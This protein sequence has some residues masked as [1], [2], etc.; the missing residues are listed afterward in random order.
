MPKKIKYQSFVYRFLAEAQL[1]QRSMGEAQRSGWQQFVDR[2]RF[3]Y[4]RGNA[5]VSW[6]DN[7]ADRLSF[8]LRAADFYARGD[9]R[10]HVARQREANLL[11]GKDAIQ[12]KNAA[13][14]R[15][16]LLAVAR[17]AGVNPVPETGAVPVRDRARLDAEEAFHDQWAE[18]VDPTPFDVRKANE[19]CTSP[20]MRYIRAQLGSL[21]GKKLLDV[22][23]GLGE[24]SVYF[25]LEGARVTA[26]DISQGMLEAT[27]RLARLNGVMV[28][29]HKSA[30]EQTNLPEREAFDIIYA[31][32]LLHHVDIEATL[33]LLKPHLAADGV[34]VSWDPVAYN[35]VIK[36]YRAIATRVRTPDE[37]PLRRADLR[38]IKREF[39]Q[40]E[41][42]FF[43]LTSLLIFICMAVLQRRS[44]NRERFWK[45]VVAESDRWEPLYRPL[46]RLD[47]CLLRM[48][49]PLRW[50]CWN[51]VIVARNPVG[52]PR[53]G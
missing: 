3:H 28:A 19:A 15:Q 44:P 25:A 41:T 20:E 29:T 17:R 24:A 38:L 36:V 37:H 33:R 52:S 16:A 51:V 2:L 53:S 50:L 26:M 35:P 22:G 40:V 47:D 23:C 32:N 43:W 1:A 49:P 10:Q 34:F 8:A 9:A 7:D 18:A 4:D 30:A 46:R 45:A 42:R 31:G 13:Y 12:Q 39:R 21:G 14:F 48:M 5:V 11:F 6:S 27:S